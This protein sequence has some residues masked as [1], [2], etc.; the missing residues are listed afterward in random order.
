M[1]PE[2]IDMNKHRLFRFN[3]WSENY[4]EYAS[5]DGLVLRMST[6]YDSCLEGIMSLI[7][8]YEEKGR[9][10]VIHKSPNID[11]VVFASND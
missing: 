1:V 6:K 2:Y 9:F 4:C 11:D 10:F 8:L 3:Y 7:E 5:D